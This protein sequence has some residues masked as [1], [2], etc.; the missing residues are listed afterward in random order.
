MDSDFNDI[1]PSDGTSS[2]NLFRKVIDW[3]CALLILFTIFSIIIT[4]INFNR[5][6]N[7]DDG[8]L[9]HKEVIKGEKNY[10]MKTSYYLI[11]KIVRVDNKT[12]SQ[13]Y[14]RFFF[15]DDIDY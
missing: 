7:G 14:F 3:I 5:I 4:I 13:S 12:G 15:M 11:Y 6:S 2:K 10:D 8:L 9:V 1:T